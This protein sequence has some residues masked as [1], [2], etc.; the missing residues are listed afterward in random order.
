MKLFEV[1]EDEIDILKYHK[2]LVDSHQGAIVTFTGHVR[3][4][5]KGTRTVY[6]EYEAYVPMAEKMLAQIGDEIGEK[7]PGVKTAICHRIGKL[8]QTE[9]AV[10]V[11]T[12]SPHR[13]EGYLANMYAVDRLKEIVPIWKKEIWEDGEE[14]IGDSRHYHS[15]VNEE[16]INGD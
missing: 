14:W 10:V 16:D 3:E 6:L 4:W 13:Q 8:D 1:T 9:V 5:T 15:S 11:V 2:A 7:W 12:S